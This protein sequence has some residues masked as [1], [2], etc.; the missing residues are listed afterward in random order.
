LIT[1]DRI[2]HKVDSARVPL[3]LVDE[4]RTLSLEEPTFLCSHEFKFGSSVKSADR[5]GSPFESPRLADR[6]GAFDDDRR[7]IG[8]IEL[9]SRNLGT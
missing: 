6:L 2:A 1:V 4:D 7:K 9:L 8:S 3:E 5:S